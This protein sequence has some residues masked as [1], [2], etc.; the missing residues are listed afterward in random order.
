MSKQPSPAP[1]ASAVGPCPTLFQTSRTP[2]HWKFTQNH[3]TTRPPP[4]KKMKHYPALDHEE[5]ETLSSSGSWRRWNTIQLCSS[6]SCRRRNTIQ[7]CIMKKMKHY[8]ALYHEE[9]E[10][11]SRIVS[12]RRWNTIR[13]WIMQ[14][15]KHY[16]TLDHA[17]YE[18]LSS[19]VSWRTWTAIQ[20]CIISP[21]NR[22]MFA[23][24][25]EIYSVVRKL[26]VGSWSFRS[27]FLSEFLDSTW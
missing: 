20:L 19:S 16:P 11:L 5:D 15:M 22:T 9:D 13:F 14:N 18:T 24:Q 25:N 6:V 10:T 27:W 1:T 8:P 26:K 23:L 2:R 17:E 3:R 12:W 4:I 21:H 7:L